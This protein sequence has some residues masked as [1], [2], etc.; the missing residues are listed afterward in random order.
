MKKKDDKDDESSGRVSRAERL[1]NEVKKLLSKDT[2]K[3]S[4]VSPREFTDRAAVQ[5]ENLPTVPFKKKP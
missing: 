1:A 4:I 2:A 5:G 3:E